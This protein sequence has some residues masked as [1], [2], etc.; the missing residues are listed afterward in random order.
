[1]TYGRP[2]Q[3]LILGAVS[4][5][6]LMVR[7][8]SAYVEVPYTLGRVLQEASFVLTMRVE[9]VDKE[10]NLILYRK[11]QN[12]KGNYPVEVIKHNIGR[13]GFHPREWQTIM[14]WAEVGKTAVFFHNGGASETCIDNYWYQAYAN[15]EWWGLSHAE[16]FLLRSF[17]GRP[18][19]LATAVTAM[20][21]GQEVVVPCMVDG[22]KNAL[23]LRTAKIQR[24][25]AS[26]KLQDYN[27]QRDFVGW[28]GEDFRRITGM[29]GFTHL[30]AIGRVDPG[31]RGV[32]PADFDGD[33]KLD[34]CLFG[35]G[36]TTVLQNGGSAF[37]EISLPY[38]GGARAA[39]WSDYNGDG[40]TDLLLLAP[41][42]PRLLA[43]RG[44]SFSD[45]SAGLPSE[46]YSSLTAGAWLDYDLDG[47]PDLLVSDRFR[48]LRLYRNLV[49]PAAAAIAAGPK[50]GKWR[51]AG[52]FDDASGRGFDTV[53][54]PERSV[55]L[56]AQYD[57][58]NG[59]KAVW[60]ERDFTDGQVHSL[61]LFQPQNNSNAIVFLYREI[62]TPVPTEVPVSLGSDDALIVWLNGERLLAEN[63]QRGA[64]ADQ[65]HV[66]LLLKPGRNAFLMKICQGG[67]EWGFYFKAGQ[68][69]ALPAPLFTDVSDQVGLGQS[70]LAANEPG[71]HLV[72]ADFNGDGRPDFLCG[73]RGNVLALNTP[74]GFVAAKNTG[75]DFSAGKIAP[76]CADLNGDRHVDVLVLG[77][78]G[79]LVFQND[80]SARFTNATARAG[81]VVAGIQQPTS[82]ALADFNGDH[83]LD[84]F[85]GCLKGPNRYFRNRGD[86]SWVDAGDEIGLYQKVFNT[87]GIAVADLNADGAP[88]L[89]LNNEGQD[90]A[91]LLGAPQRTALLPGAGQ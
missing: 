6:L 74:R 34:L 51:Y 69:I 43:N 83:R 33:G 89:V 65:A 9:K 60:R 5:T 41:A 66:K 84:L 42:G 35:G 68:P 53:F 2:F 37:N 32:A 47:R 13:G 30:G 17:A 21:G 76:L 19:K 36:R 91:I 58:K 44:S 82:A 56:T 88:D 55:D 79:A 24:L 48:G 52:P 38:V 23:H 64:A 78:S 86:G 50:F 8:T 63:V 39:A 16:P 57:G 87:G 15:G 54:P 18:E 59:E 85:V 45:E 46:P 25:K 22:D 71:E 10:K 27:A 1:M 49:T 11:V 80:G 4:A 40:K 67:G 61:A 28:G 7:D 75:L 29:P 14:D 70:G 31:V 62:E 77:S 81:D 3:W 20:V 90:S 12:L 72:V 26:V 73:K